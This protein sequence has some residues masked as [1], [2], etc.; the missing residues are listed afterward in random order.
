MS[1]TDF[2]LRA[3]LSRVQVGD[4][5]RSRSGLNRVVRKISRHKGRT[6]LTFVIKHCSWTG[7]CYTTYFPSD[8]K[9]AGLRPTGKR[10]KLKGKMDKRIAEAI[11]RADLSHLN[12]RVPN[13]CTVE[14]IS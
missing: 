4:I 11:R 1:A 5:L 10:L 12:G 7:R 6:I 3:W 2:K 14:G 13:C 8:V 9:H